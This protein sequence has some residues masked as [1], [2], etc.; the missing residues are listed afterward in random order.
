M[1]NNERN[2]GDTSRVHHLA[3]TC[4]ECNCNSRHDLDSGFVCS[5]QTVLP[6][7]LQS[8]IAS[9]CRWLTRGNLKL[10]RGT[11]QSCLSLHPFRLDHQHNLR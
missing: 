4:L 10:E 7:L 1:F 8:L 5:V 6:S 2:I 11:K 9:R 3:R